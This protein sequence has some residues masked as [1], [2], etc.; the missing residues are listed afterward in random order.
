MPDWKWAITP[1]HR[2]L[3][4]LIEQMSCGLIVEDEKGTI[5]YVNH[6]ILEWSGHDVKDLEGNP[7]EML[8]PPELHS[9]LGTE[10]ARTHQGDQR[11]RLSA[12]LRRNGRTFPVA[13]SPQVVET[14]DGELLVLA[15]LIELGEVQTAR[16]MGTAEGSLAA[17]LAGVAAK[18]QSMTFTASVGEIG[19]A[20]MGHP[21][22]ESLSDR[23]REVLTHLVAGSRVP[24]IAA[25]A[26]DCRDALHL[27]QH[28]AQPPEGDLPQ[29]GRLV[30]ERADRVGARAGRLPE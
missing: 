12:F 13:V 2:G 16:P 3:I 19:S 9:A 7:V 25:C 14:D 6:R 10:R 23:E 15:L 29:A 22:L 24:T 8:V 28:R 4:R 5:L 26:D 27:A 17:D 30:A 21:F 20:P 18:L 1:T 11:T